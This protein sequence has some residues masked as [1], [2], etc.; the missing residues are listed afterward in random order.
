MQIQ[1][2]KTDGVEIKTKKA[3]IYLNGEVKINDVELE[4]T[5][6]YEVGEV[7]VFGIDDNTYIFQ[8]EDM[9]ISA[10]NF[11]CKIAK[12]VVEKLSNTEVT[13]VKLNGNVSEAVEQVGQ[14]EPNITVYIGTDEA[15]AK[16]HS[17]GVSAQKTDS[18]KITKADLEGDQ[19]AYFIQVQNA[20]CQ[21]APEN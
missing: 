15:E 11:T 12:E 13:I 18:V 5:G 3:L 9:S 6:E 1:K 8:A 7:S 14:I 16:L 10:V 2:S 20:K 19:K 4:G 17:G 21:T